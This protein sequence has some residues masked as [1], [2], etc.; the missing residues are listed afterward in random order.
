MKA[1][2]VVNNHLLP[3][4]HVTRSSGLPA[5][6]TGG[7]SVR[8][9]NTAAAFPL[10]GCQQ[11]GSHSPWPHK[12]PW[13]PLTHPEGD[14]PVTC[15]FSS[16]LL[17]PNANREMGTSATATLNKEKR[18]LSPG[19]AP[20]ALNSSRTW[21]PREIRTMEQGDNDWVLSSCFTCGGTEQAETNTSGLTYSVLSAW[22]FRAR[23]ET[24][25]EFLY[26]RR[27]P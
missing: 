19:L 17:N 18:S 25:W 15:W 13:E 16:V 14:L 2:G 23:E 21:R 20:V 24:S 3:A 1:C 5:F 22:Q 8:T 26:R 12:L 27:H 4:K 6:L 10:Q 9:A 7:G 11:A